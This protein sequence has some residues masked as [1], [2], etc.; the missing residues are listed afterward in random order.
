MGLFDAFKKKVEEKSEVVNPL[1]GYLKD[2]GLPIENLQVSESNGSVTVTGLAEN[3]ET[4]S[5]VEDML[6]AKGVS[7]IH[8]NVNVVDHSN[9]GVTYKV[10]TKGSNLN[11]RKG[12]TTTDEIVGKFANGSVVSLVQKHNDTWHMVKNDEITGYCHT[13]YLDHM[14]N[15]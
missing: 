6:K 10:T 14:S 5:L 4:L 7:T 8:N 9:S 11:C 1:Y 12:P 2:A 13:D 15:T 3:G